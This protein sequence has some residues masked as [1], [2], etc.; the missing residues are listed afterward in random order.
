MRY[1]KR[2]LGT[3]L[4]ITGFERFFRDSEAI[5]ARAAGNMNLYREYMGYAVALGHVDEWVGAMPAEVSAALV[6]AVPVASLADVAF[7]PLWLASSRRYTA[8]HTVKSRSSFSSGG[9]F[10]G[11]GFSGGGGGGGGGGSW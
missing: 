1:T 3:V 9:G 7:H 4:R 2:G 11:G 5:H 8:A 6:G 10:S